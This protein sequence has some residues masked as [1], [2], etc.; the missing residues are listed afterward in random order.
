MGVSLSEH[1]APARLDL[2]A[3]LTLLKPVT[4]FP[5]MW[6]FT[7]GAISA[8]VPFTNERWWT[9]ALG[10]GLTGPMVCASSQAVNDWFDRHVDAI[11][12]PQRPIPSG[13]IPGQ[14]GLV[15]AIGWSLLCVI[16]ALP[17]GTFGLTAVA[18]ALAFSWAYSAPPFRFKRNGWLGNAAVGFT[19]E[20][21]AWVTGAGIML[22]STLPGTNV[23]L[24]AALYSLGAHGIMTLNDF[25]AMAGDERMGVRS[26]PVLHG[27]KGAAW[28]ASL[29]MLAAQAV[30][31]VLLTSWGRP[32][33]ALAIGVLAAVQAGLMLWFVRAPESRALYLSAFGVPFYVSGMMVSAFALRAL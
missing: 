19:Y 30:V 7:C 28:L 1:S 29:I 27:A 2:S 21:L 33:H 12:E 31:I 17:L 9:L 11:N 3:V 16:W 13:R 8:G 18:L 14:W 24:V 15:I 10:I 26:L 22:G 6:A 20:G 32:M 23:L 25:K 4:W 5:P